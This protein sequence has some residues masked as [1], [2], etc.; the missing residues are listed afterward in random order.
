MSSTSGLASQASSRGGSS[1]GSGFFGV[2]IGSYRGF[3]DGHER[4]SWLPRITAQGRQ[5]FRAIMT[6]GNIADFLAPPKNQ[7]QIGDPKDG[8]G[9]RGGGSF[10]TFKQ[11]YSGG[12]SGNS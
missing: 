5:R 10:A 11:P 6:F 7:V 2:S 3:D 8:G 12:G 1:F 4:F 9:K